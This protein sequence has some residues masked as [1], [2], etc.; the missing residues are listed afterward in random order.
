MLDY[1]VH[2]PLCKHATG[3][4]AAMVQAAFDAGLKEIAFLDHLTLPPLPTDH[5]MAAKD[6]PFYLN[7]I[8]ELAVAWEGKI[9]VLAGLEIDFHPESLEAIRHIIQSYDLDMVAGSVHFVQG[10][11]IAS[12]SRRNTW[13]HLPPLPLFHAYIDAMETLVAADFCDILCHLDLMDKFA[14]DLSPEERK[15]T[16]RR[17]EKLLDAVSQ[18]KLVVEINGSGL[19]QPMGRPYPSDFLL[20]ACKK[21][22]IPV[23]L[24]SDAHRPE[25]VGKYTETLLGH[26]RAA[27]Y[28]SIAGFDRRRQRILPLAS[29]LQ[30]ADYPPKETPCA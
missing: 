2:T 1:H 15:Q 21:R 6:V 4:P 3:R 28:D 7:C 5:S 16:D 19:D 24:A 9:R 12:R 17:M 8:R 22:N 14:P 29:L 25:S 27:G 23:T 30:K 18:K 20:K 10:H 13:S 26:I 11:N